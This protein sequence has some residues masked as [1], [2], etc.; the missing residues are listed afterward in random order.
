M[1]KQLFKLTAFISLLIALM[2]FITCSNDLLGLFVSSDLDERLKSKDTFNLLDGSD[3]EADFGAE[4]SFVVFTDTHI[5][6]GNTYGLEGLTDVISGNPKIKFAVALGDITQY[7]S[8]HDLQ[9]FIDISN[10]FGIPCYPVIGNHDFYFDNWSVWNDNIGS[11]SYKVNGTGTT[12]F[13]LD[14]A[15][16]YFGKKQLDWLESEIKKL[17][18]SEH[19]FVFTHAPLFI[20]GPADMQQLTDIKER[21]RIVSILKDKCDTMFMGHLHKRLENTVGNVKYLGIEDFR[22][23]KTYCV[24]TVSASGVTYEFKKL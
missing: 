21:A 8:E 18:N 13:I 10:G 12:L 2:L 3:L 15:S 16:T 1:V 11:T 7:G 14:S 19:I 24:V 17:D 6:D 20:N 23:T 5:E 9:K 22:S 4:Y